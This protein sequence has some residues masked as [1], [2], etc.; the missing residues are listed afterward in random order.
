MGAEEAVLESIYITPQADMVYTYP[1]IQ[2]I[3]GAIGVVVRGSDK[4]STHGAIEVVP[5]ILKN[6]VA[7]VRIVGSVAQTI[8]IVPRT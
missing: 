1:A 3:Y 7:V 4:R 5:T 8:A 6:A 2:G